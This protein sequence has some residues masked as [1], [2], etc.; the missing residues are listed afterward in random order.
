MIRSHLR[1]GQPMTTM[2]S[3]AFTNSTPSTRLEVITSTHSLII[4]TPSWESHYFGT[5]TLELC[6]RWVLN[7]KVGINFI[8]NFILFSSAVPQQAYDVVSTL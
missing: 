5:I 3:L 2:S 4:I 1:K 7:L 6:Y 8:C